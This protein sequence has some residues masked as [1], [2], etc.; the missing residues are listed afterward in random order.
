MPY[1]QVEDVNDF[2]GAQEFW[3][4]NDCGAHA[5]KPENV[6]HHDSC[7][8]GESKKWEKFYGENQDE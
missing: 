4:C 7:T 2:E 3:S 1:T 5:D 8:P 6:K